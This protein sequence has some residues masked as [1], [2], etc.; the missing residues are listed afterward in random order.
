MR[1]IARR[2]S[3]TMRKHTGWVTVCLVCLYAVLYAYPVDITH[4]AVT[5]ATTW[6]EHAGGVAVLTDE[7]HPGNSALSD[8][9]AW[10]NKGILVFEFPSPV[11]V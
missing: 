8:A 2:W 9:F 4:D 1:D 3:M 11:V 10:Q 7:E 5:R 6:N